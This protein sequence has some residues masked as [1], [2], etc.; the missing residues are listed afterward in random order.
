M[1]SSVFQGVQKFPWY[2]RW[3][4]VGSLMFGSYKIAESLFGT[5]FAWAA[6]FGMV[7]VPAVGLIVG[8]NIFKGG[9]FNERKEDGIAG[10]TSFLNNLGSQL[11]ETLKE[12]GAKMAKEALEGKSKAEPA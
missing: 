3:V 7:L 1:G 9:S 8:L 5:I 11:L 12:E 6:H 2:I 4:I 10:W